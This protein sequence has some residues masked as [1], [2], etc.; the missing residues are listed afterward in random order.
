M[1]AG[2]VLFIYENA[3]HTQYMAANDTAR[4]IGALDLTISSV[5]ENYKTTKKWL[6][7]GISTEDMGHYLN[8]GLISQKEG[9]G[10]RTN[11]YQ[12]WRVKI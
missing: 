7:F 2:T 9:F 3:I 11:I 8:E 6:D 12:T 1:I 10:G 4:E 5:I